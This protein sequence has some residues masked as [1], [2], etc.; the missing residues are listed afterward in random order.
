MGARSTPVGTEVPA[1]WC[2]EMAPAS[3]AEAF[4]LRQ[5]LVLKVDGDC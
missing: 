2:G 1:S 4:V 3:S 5:A